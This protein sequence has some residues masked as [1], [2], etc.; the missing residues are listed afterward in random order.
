MIYV[1]SHVAALT[2]LGVVWMTLQI[3]NN[4]PN[5]ALLG[6]Q[7][8]PSMLHPE[9]FPA[10]LKDNPLATDQPHYPSPVRGQLSEKSRR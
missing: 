8:V 6:R 4:G 9:N 3:I 7:A 5:P 10:P 2:A 1:T